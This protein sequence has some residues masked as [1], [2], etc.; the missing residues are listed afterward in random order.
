MKQALA[1]LLLLGCGDDATRGARTAEE[2]VQSDLIAQCPPG[3]DPRLDAEAK[4]LCEG[5]ADADLIAWTAQ[6][7]D[8]LYP[9]PERADV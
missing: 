8:Q 1:L 2:C 3:S 4:T 9:L 6:L 7:L 5:A